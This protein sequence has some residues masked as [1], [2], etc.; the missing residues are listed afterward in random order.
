[1]Y[2][3]ANINVKPARRIAH[4]YL[5]LSLARAVFPYR[6][7]AR[8]SSYKTANVGRCVYTLFNIRCGGST[9]VSGG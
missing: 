3:G 6:V 7:I 1:M 8:V 4:G 9:T 5:S 2:R